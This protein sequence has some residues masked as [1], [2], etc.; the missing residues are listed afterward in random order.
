VLN[1][2]LRPNWFKYP[3]EYSRV[4][5]LKIVNLEPWFFLDGEE[6]ESRYRGLKERFPTAELIPFARRADNDD[7]AC[8]EKSGGNLKVYVVHD[9]SRWGWE[10]H[11]EYEDFWSWYRKAMEDMIEHEQPYR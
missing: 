11:K 9:F 10:K 3:K 7:V 1:E 8:W 6:L 4:V 5:D 2:A